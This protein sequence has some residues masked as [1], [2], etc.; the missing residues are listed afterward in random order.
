LLSGFHELF[1]NAFLGEDP[2]AMDKYFAVTEFCMNVW[3]LPE[4]GA[5]SGSR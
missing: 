3:F 1:G 4:G 5:E 2:L